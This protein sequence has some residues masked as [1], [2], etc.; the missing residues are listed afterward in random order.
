MNNR[1]E[2]TFN[3]GA[4]ESTDINAEEETLLAEM[5][6]LANEAGDSRDHLPYEVAL[7]FHEQSKITKA[8]K[9]HVDDC[10]YC[11][12]LIDTL[13]PSDRVI[14]ELQNA[15]NKNKTEEAPAVAAPDR[16][17]KRTQVKIPISIAASIVI[18]IFISPFVITP[19]YDASKSKATGLEKAAVSMLIS[20]PIYLDTLESSDQPLAKFQAARIYLATKH[21]YLAYQRI[22]E[23][24]ALAKLDAHMVNTVAT[25]PKLS[26]DASGSLSKA[27]NEL[28]SISAKQSLDK[29]EVLRVVQLQAQLGQ[30]EQA[31]RS[32]RTYLVKTGVD[33]YVLEDFT[34]GTLG[35]NKTG[36]WANNYAR[37]E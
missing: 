12:R 11:R 15:L 16:S 37:T 27:V 32:L 26:T 18:V 23:G 19:L 10:E 20:N 31:L 4:L 22:G 13:H 35:K 24:F 9:N 17:R 14:D 34:A 33:Q 1:K 28:R 2:N 6:T 3:A 21:P 25:A 30:H 8:Y 5:E 36:D 7:Q 29:N